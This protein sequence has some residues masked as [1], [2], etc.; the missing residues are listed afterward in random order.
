MIESLPGSKFHMAK[1]IRNT[2][3]TITRDVNVINANGTWKFESYSYA[4]LR[5]LLL[6]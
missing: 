6:D 2:E 3:I 1:E 4:K 5:G